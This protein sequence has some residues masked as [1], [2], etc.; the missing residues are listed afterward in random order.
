MNTIRFRNFL[1]MTKDEVVA[2]MV[3]FFNM[4]MPKNEHMLSNGSKI[5][6]DNGLPS[7]ILDKGLE[8]MSAYELQTIAEP[9]AEYKLEQIANKMKQSGD[10]GR[11]P[12]LI[13]MTYT[14]TTSLQFTPYFMNC[15]Y[16]DDYQAP[17]G[18]AEGYG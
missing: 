7:I 4:M 3:Q 15:I 2:D 11:P 14:D 8:N 18:I 13:I 12:I 9:W 6:I 16:K 1:L 10:I 5:A 17:V